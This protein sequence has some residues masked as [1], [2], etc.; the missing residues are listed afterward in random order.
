[1]EKHEIQQLLSEQLGLT[2]VYV[3]TDGSHYTVTAVGECFAG[4]SRVKQQ[5][6]VYSPLMP[7]IA[8]GSI[9]AVS[10]KTFTPEQWRR[11]KLLNP[12]I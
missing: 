7:A 12:P 5:Q 1:M 2:E 4:Q 8:D 11:E 6:M 10:I 3:N 9:H